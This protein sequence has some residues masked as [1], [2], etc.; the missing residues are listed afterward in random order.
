MFILIGSWKFLAS[1]DVCRVKRDWWLTSWSGAFKYDPMDKKFHWPFHAPVNA[2]N[3]E[4]SHLVFSQCNR[5][6]VFAFSAALLWQ[7]DNPYRYHQT[8]QIAAT[9]DFFA[10]ALSLLLF[11]R[12]A[13]TLWWVSEMSVSGCCHKQSGGLFFIANLFQRFIV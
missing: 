11:I 10:I 13:S 7:R 3:C 4:L 8:I 5:Q 9:L 2:M 1:Y 6:V 12:R